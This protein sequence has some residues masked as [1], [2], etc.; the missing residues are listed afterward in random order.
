MHLAHWTRRREAVWTVRLAGLAVAAAALGWT[1]APMQ[2][3]APSAR[4]TPLAP[5][6]APKIIDSSEAYPGSSYV[7]QHLVDGNERTEYSSQGK[8]TATLA[9]FDFGQPVRLVAFEH[10]DR[11]DPATV[12]ASELTLSDTAEFAKIA[13]KLGVRHANTRAGRTMYVFPAPVT[14][15][16]V[17]WQVTELGPQKYGTVGGAEIRFY[18]AAEPEPTPSR[19]TVELVAQPAVVLEGAKRIR[20]LRAEIHHPYAEPAEAR[21]SVSGVPGALRVEA[22]RQLGTGR[23]TLDI[24]LAAQDAPV[25]V[26]VSLLV[27]GQ[28]VV[29]KALVLQPVR[30]WEL[31]ILP[32]SHVDIGY[33]N[34]QTEIEKLQWKYL[35]EAIAIARRTA[36]YPPGAQFKWNAEVLWAVDS[37]LKQAAPERRR[38][39]I[40]AVK[41]GQVHLDALYGNMLTGLCRPEELFRLFDCARRLQGEC[42][43]TIDAAMISDVPGWTWGIVPAMAHNGV[44]YFSMG[45][46]HIHRIGS[47]LEDWGDKPFYWVSPSGEEKVLCWAA[48]KGYSWFHPGL[49][50]RINKVKPE[51]FFAHLEQLEK[52]G[53]PYEIVQLRYSIG[54]DN[55]PPD[56]ELP[57]FVKKWNERYAWPKLR[58]ATTRELFA[59]FERRYRD[60]IPQ[61]RGDFTP[62]WEDGAGSSARETALAR[63]AAECLVQAETLFAMLKPAQFPRDDFYRAW[64]NVLLYNE[65]TWGAHCSITQPDSDF[66]KAQWK[67]KQAFALDSS[68][69]SQKLLFAGMSDR[70]G[71]AMN[72]AVLEVINTTSWPRTDLIPVPLAR[73]A[74]ERRVVK[75][76]EGRIV[77]SQALSTGLMFLAK[78]VP[79]LGAARFYLE[80]GQPAT[81][82]QAKAEKNL[83]A[84]SS[85]RLAVDEKSG[86]ID[87]LRFGGI[88]VDLAK[89][90]AGQGLNE[91]FYVA[92]RDPKQPQR[93]LAVKALQRESGPLVATLQ[94]LCEAPGGTTLQR[95][96]R[97]TDGLDRVEILDTG[98]KA[99]V[100]TSEG[101]HFGFALNVPGGVM[102]MDVPWGVMRPELDQL[103][104]ACKNYFSVGRWIDVSN[105]QFGV[106]CA[107]IDAPLAEV[108]AIT[109]DVA[110]PFDPKAWIRRLAPTQTFYSYVMNNYWETNYKADNEGEFVFR[111]ALRPHRQFDPA[112]ATRFGIEQSQPLVVVPVAKD[113][114]ALRSMF[115]VEPPAVLLTSLKPSEDGKALMLRLWNAGDRPAKARVNW[116]AFQPKRVAL[117]SP[118]EDEGAAWSG[119]ELPPL[120]I[121]T[122][123]AT[124]K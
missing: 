79:P 89:G 49:L 39:F 85:I 75:D 46:N 112:A 40:E 69:Q 20:T 106:T 67:I 117:S 86:A 107:T 53:F 71:P 37:Y 18:A 96:I 64:R 54:G 50:D 78:D 90:P 24:P 33:T 109:T 15:R 5:L 51:S 82:G 84:T 92:G 66:T 44:K 38:E 119:T 72:Y 11:A 124:R 6:P 19:T 73:S 108:G 102:R 94:V 42:G 110:S 29:D 25:N 58:I 4:F 95:A 30:H 10:V 47:T 41:A 88:A 59:E 97:V 113:A 12:G 62:Y 8:G 31:Y 23:Q 9:V 2:A 36:S 21:L 45:P 70:S 16:Y 28:K 60:K 91:Y 101:V 68:E 7:V 80:E 83:L 87:S 14:A 100:R 56:P 55:G 61:A 48:G 122:L 98:R 63:N 26:Q 1:A 116:A 81:Q 105:D 123:R 27:A 35:D 115:S 74:A 34:V 3:D 118:K 32:H 111:Y 57:D 114:P 52:G 120:G 121:V 77:P 43:V 93:C 76:S 13:G 104:G 22:A 65:H 99:R 103:P 17:R